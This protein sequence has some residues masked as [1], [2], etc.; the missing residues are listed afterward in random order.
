MID[1]SMATPEVQFGE[2][3]FYWGYRNMGKGLHIG[4]EMIWR[5]LHH[6]SPTYHGL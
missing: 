1:Q 6:Q 4:T 5:Q 3:I 2:P